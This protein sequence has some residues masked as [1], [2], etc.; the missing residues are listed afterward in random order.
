MHDHH[1]EAV[2]RKNFIR[3]KIKALAA[4]CLFLGFFAGLFLGISYYRIFAGNG[5]P[6]IMRLKGYKFI[7]PLLDYET[8]PELRNKEIIGLKQALEKIIKDKIEKNQAIYISVYFRD[9]LNGPWFGINERDNFAPASLLKVPIMIAY[10]K[11][12]EQ[13]PEIL[14]C[15]IAYD[16]EIQDD[17]RQNIHPDKK[18]ELGKSYSVEELIYRM[19]VYSDNTAKNLLL[20]NIDEGVI[21]RVY[22]DIGIIIP[23]IRGKTDFIATKEYASFFS[24]LFN[25]SYLNREM[26]EKAL[27]ILSQSTFKIGIPSGVPADIIVAHKFAERGDT[28]NQTF[29]LHDCGIVYYKERPYLLCVMTYGRDFEELDAIVKKISEVTY[30][31]IDSYYK[32]YK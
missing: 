12:A 11:H 25:A 24:I 9:M 5:K 28:V 14:Q 7:S 15:N 20:N 4:A 32:K 1:N 16:K 31:E 30:K 10:F 2:E 22:T 27:N 13:N 8:K 19:T 17:T 21:D 23:H 29:Q 6:E 26:S 3:R 18:L